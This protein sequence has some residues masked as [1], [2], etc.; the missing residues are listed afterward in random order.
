MDVGVP[1]VGG[2]MATVLVAFNTGCSSEVDMYGLRKNNHHKKP[3]V[4][5][6]TRIISTINT[7]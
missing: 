4:N 2:D 5:T 6:V 1:V 3:Y 7:L